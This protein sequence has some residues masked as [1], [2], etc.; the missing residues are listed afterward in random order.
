MANWNTNYTNMDELDNLFRSWYMDLMDNKEYI[1]GL[2]QEKT[3]KLHINYEVA[4]HEIPTMT[5]IVE[6]L[7]Y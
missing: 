2:L 3:T 1:H 7:S 5:I 6:K 4:A